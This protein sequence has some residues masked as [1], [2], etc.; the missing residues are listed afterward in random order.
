MI[1]E[2]VDVVRLRVHALITQAPASRQV[3][4]T[5]LHQ[6][7]VPAALNSGS[8][9][10]ELVRQFALRSRRRSQ[11]VA[12]ARCVSRTNDAEMPVSP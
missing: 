9:E 11:G 5:C 8:R 12:E 2:K 4:E 1:P 3:L 7:R 10:I 6:S